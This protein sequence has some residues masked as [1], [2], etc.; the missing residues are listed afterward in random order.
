MS[1]AGMLWID[2]IFDKQFINKM[3]EAYDQTLDKYCKKILMLAK[4]E[5]DIPL[6]YAI[7]EISK[8]LKIAPPKLD[9]TIDM[10]RDEGFEA[11]RTS[12]M[13]NGFRTNADYKQIID[14]IESRN[15]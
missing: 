10:L 7:D 13:L 2:N 11:S 5:L 6:Y 14:I 9:K 15:R 3:I 12:L 1:K 8:Q 4:D